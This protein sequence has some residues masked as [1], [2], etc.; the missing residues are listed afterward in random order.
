MGFEPKKSRGSYNKT[1]IE[2]VEAK[3][4]KDYDNRYKGNKTRKSLKLTSIS[5]K[6]KE[7]EINCNRPSV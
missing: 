1:Q 6:G 7:Y 3:R 2:K 5:T 4:V